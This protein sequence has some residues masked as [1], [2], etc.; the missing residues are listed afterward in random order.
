MLG[1]TVVHDKVPWFWSDQY[2]LKLLIVGLS[3]GYD[4][5]V[6]RGDPAAHSFCVCYLRDGELIALDAVNEREGLHGR[7]QA[8]RGARASRRA[9]A[10]RMPPIQLKDAH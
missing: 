10:S 9:H 8:H 1:K 2:D 3:H 6:L 4:Q 5:C 7:T